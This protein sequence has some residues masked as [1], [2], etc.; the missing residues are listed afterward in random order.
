M[1]LLLHLVGLAAL[2]GLYQFAWHRGFTEA[3]KRWTEA[4]QAR[5]IGRVR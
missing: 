1:I 4:G 2:V 5:D 3:V